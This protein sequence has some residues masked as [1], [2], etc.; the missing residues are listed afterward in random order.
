[1]NSRLNRLSTWEAGITEHKFHFFTITMNGNR[2]ASILFI[3]AGLCF[4]ISGIMAVSAVYIALAVVFV[5]LSVIFQRRAKKEN[6]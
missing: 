1:M 4:L 5:C 2:V 6:M 3:L